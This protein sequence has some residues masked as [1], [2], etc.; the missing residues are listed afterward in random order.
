[1]A[2]LCGCQAGMSMGLSLS[3]VGGIKY[4]YYV[5]RDKA[6]YPLK[7]ILLMFVFAYST[8]VTFFIF[9]AAGPST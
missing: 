2:K 7:I 5:I 6:I 4:G 9:G 3:A 8:V 1:M